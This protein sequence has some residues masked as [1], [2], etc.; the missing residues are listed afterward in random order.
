MIHEVPDEQSYFNPSIS[1][2]DPE[3]GNKIYILPESSTITI[4]F[5]FGKILGLQTN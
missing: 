2:L 4:V 5:P 1:V 3:M